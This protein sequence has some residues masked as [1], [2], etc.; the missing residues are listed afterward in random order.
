MSVF[1]QWHLFIFALLILTMLHINDIPDQ[2]IYHIINW[3]C[4]GYKDAKDFKHRLPLLAVNRKFRLSGI[5]SVYD[6]LFVMA[7]K[8][9]SKL[10]V[11]SNI[12]LF[13]FPEYCAFVKKVKLDSQNPSNL[14]KGPL[15]PVIRLMDNLLVTLYNTMPLLKEDLLPNAPLVAERFIEMFPNIGRVDLDA[16][17][18]KMEAREFA[19]KW[20]NILGSQLTALHSNI[21][22]DGTVTQS[23][24]ELTTVTFS[25]NMSSAELL[26]AINPLPLEFL[27]I[28]DP[29][30]GFSWQCFQ[31]KNGILVFPNLTTLYF[32]CDGVRGGDEDLM[33]A[34]K[35]DASPGSLR[36]Q[37]PNLKVFD[38]RVRNADGIVFRPEIIPS[39]LEELR[40]L[41]QD[42]AF[43]EFGQL[44]IES[45]G[46]LDVHISESYAIF[47]DAFYD[48]SN[49]LF[50]EVTITKEAS[51]RLGVDQTDVIDIEQIQWTNVSVLEIDYRDL[52]CCVSYLYKI[53]TLRKLEL[54][55][56]EAILDGE[57][58]NTIPTEPIA[59][60]RDHGLE[61]LAIDNLNTGWL[62]KYDVALTACLVKSLRNLKKLIIPREKSEEIVEVFK[63][64]ARKHP[65][66]NNIRIAYCAS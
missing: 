5:S 65:H 49:R 4:S 13:Q 6:N 59:E 21:P 40:M 54:N 42:I 57:E 17:S 46:C 8:T 58:I 1:A 26:P 35:E 51:V 50:G 31:P 2:A 36:L 20:V 63:N 7:T 14:S 16:E 9:S 19:S 53:P 33:D 55:A 32:S 56:W 34:L 61:E 62:T 27:H 29:P 39:H 28:V 43:L 15:D 12:G 3:V 41:I 37:F 48:I 38:T 64:S 25:C 52:Q 24:L 30:R 10:D 66:I 22:F 18:F 45:V 47:D 44:P 60:L 11:F 23:L